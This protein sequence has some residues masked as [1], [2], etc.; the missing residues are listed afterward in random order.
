VNGYALTAAI[1]QAIASLAWPAA[2]FGC[3]WLFR[4]KITELLP[5][6]RLKHKDWEASF[7][8]E[9]AEKEA[10]A[11]PAPPQGGEETQPT[12][13]EK[14]RF[15]QLA[16][17]SPEAAIVELRK[18]IEHAVKTFWS[19]HGSGTTP[20]SMLMAIR[21]L[22][23]KGLIDARTSALL[24]DLRVIGNEAAHPGEDSRFTKE[25]A[26]RYRALADQVI[27]RLNA[28]EMKQMLQ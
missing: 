14:N 10:A 15:E 3:V 25:E 16:E 18:E 11:L 9:Q 19:R 6:F 17:I 28:A 27:A 23:S 5:S 20:Q 22:R 26:M 24:D 7:R 12:P 4:A 13:E 2:I 8:L 21:S 1:I